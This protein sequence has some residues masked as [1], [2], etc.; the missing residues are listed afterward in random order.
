M[1]E[2]LENQEQSGLVASLALSPEKVGARLNHAM[3][4][5]A[6]SIVTR[7][8]VRAGL[9]AVELVPPGLVIN[10]DTQA[11]AHA[12][13][14]RAILKGL[15]DLDQ[16]L[17]ELNRIPDSMKAAAR[18]AV[19]KERE[20]LEAAKVRANDVRVVWQREMRRRAE[21]EE[22]KLRAAAAE[23]ALDETDFGGMGGPP[24]A[25]VAP[26]IVPR[27]VKGGSSAQGTQIR[28]FAAEI[29]HDLECPK[30]WK[31][32][33]PSL[34]LAAFN[35]AVARGDVKKPGPGESVVWKGVRW[36]GRETAVNR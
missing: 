19:A 35:A 11:A 17:R 9:A 23:A 21:E 22:E 2:A 1:T 25:E 3:R 31:Q 5:V 4:V 34:P 20:R 29:V 28:T 18:A 32:L 15:S 27:V 24:P 13:A 26:V 12:D 6:E 8:D 30:E 36:E 14:T 7:H 10:D 33:V 16:Q